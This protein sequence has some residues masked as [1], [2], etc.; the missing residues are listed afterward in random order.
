M[1]EGLGMKSKCAWIV[2]VACML[3]APA[4]ARDKKQVPDADVV[5]RQIKAVGYKVGGTPIKVDLI[6]TTAA[7]KANGY[8]VVEAKQAETLIDVK[9]KKLPQATTLGPEFLTYVLWT[10]TPDGNTTN[11]GEIPIDKDGEGSLKTTSKLQT[12]ALIV[13]AEPY[14]AV[15]IPS[16]VVALE[17]NVKKHVNGTIYP[18]NSY[19]LM[20]RAQYEQHGN[21]LAL[22]PDLKKAPLDVYEARNAVN[23]AKAE[24]AEKYAPDI[25]AKAIT[26]L[27]N[28]EMRVEKGKNDKQ[29]ITDAR[30]TIQ[31]AE[32]ARAL[33]QD[34][35]EAERI[36]REKD[37]AAQAA[38]QKSKEEADARAAEEAQRQ[39][40]IN[41]AKQ[42]QAKAEA[43]AAAARAQA[44]AQQQA[45][46]AKAQADADAAKAKQQADAEAA[47]AKQQADAQTAASQAREQ[48]ARD[49]AERARAQEAA[50]RAQLLQQ[51]NSILQTRDTPR[52]LVVNMADVLF[53]FNKYDLK[54]DAQ[55]KLA[56]LAGVIEQH[57]DLHLTIEGHTDSIGTDDANLKLSQERADMVRSFL[58]EQ[59]LPPQN[60]S[61]EGLGKADPVADNSTAEGR[62][63]NRR[64]EII[65][66]GQAIG[67]NLGNLNANPSANATRPQ[68][69]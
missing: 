27:Q 60:L 1:P 5:S 54:P 26:S 42:A 3:A 20:K 24:G 63:K 66:S 13:T 22:T 38:A 62:Q 10:V 68:P 52:G 35:I 61:A 49:D 41:D 67:E 65:I 44:D 34:R 53:A 7:P 55:I 47:Q 29:T 59:G 36:Q 45:A 33:T 39:Q 4:I 43:D 31:F 23:I 9:V 14:F 32:D 46:Q 58:A 6:G 12:F 11:L 40:E 8:A 19:H 50:L 51:L 28:T 25:F 48:A 56:K 16:E 69:R 15:S 30:E 17:N 21:P 2:A 64:V 37:A 18:E 57:P